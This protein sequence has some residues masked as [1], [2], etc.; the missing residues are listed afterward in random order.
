MTN[1]DTL[2]AA[3]RIVRQHLDAN[4][5]VE[6]GRGDTGCVVYHHYVARGDAQRTRCTLSLAKCKQ[7]V[8]D[9]A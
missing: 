5:Q 7:L 1:T 9:M 4:A 3:C 6:N 2:Y 8:E